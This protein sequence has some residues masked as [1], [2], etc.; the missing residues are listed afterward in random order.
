M[1]RVTACSLPDNALLQKYRKPAWTDAG[2]PY[3]DSYMTE[4]DGTH[5]VAE[6]VFAFYTTW[7]F[8]LERVILAR[9]ADRPSTDA[10][11]RDVGT[12]AT[13]SFAA[14]TVEA[15]ADDQLLM[16][17]FNSR[18]RSWFMVEPGP[19]PASTLLRFGS[20]VV[21]VADRD[22]N[23]DLGFTYRALLGFHKLYSRAL[24][25]LARR[26]LERLSG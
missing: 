9:L 5:A 3:T 11:A 7:L 25:R 19:V 17:D 23:A 2:E 20:A 12:G 26:R 13:D 10:E 18:T 24:L 21:P 14:W 1:A 22:G 15:R 8:K 6:Y 16:C 4:L